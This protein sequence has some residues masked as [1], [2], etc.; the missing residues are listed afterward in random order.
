MGKC[1]KCGEELP[2]GKKGSC[3]KCAQEYLKNWQKAKGAE[4]PWYEDFIY[5]PDRKHE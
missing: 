2:P 5:R 4:M 1:I 3:R